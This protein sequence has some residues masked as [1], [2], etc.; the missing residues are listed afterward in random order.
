L[1]CLESKSAQS[2][3][4]NSLGI[5]YSELG[6]ETD[7][8]GVLR[9]ALH[10]DLQEKNWRGV[11][12]YLRNLRVTLINLSRR[13]E[14]VTTLSLARGL[15]EA[16]H[17]ED[18]V[19]MAINDQTIEAIQQGRF[20]DA[21]VLDA[22]FRKRPKPPP[23]LYTPGDGEFW[24]CLSRFYQGK[25]TDEEWQEGYDLTVRHRNVRM[26]YVFLALRAEWDL[27][28]NRNQRALEAIDQALQITKKLGTPT[29]VYHDLRAWALA[30]LG[31]T[32]DARTELEVGSQGLYA[33]ETYLALGEREQARKC[34]LNAYRW[35]WGEG[36][37][38][39]HW[40]YLERSRALLKQLGEPEPKLPPFDPSKVQPIPYEKEIRAA[41]ERLKAERAKKEE[42]QGS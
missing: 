33:A 8:L 16:A 30:K 15:V 34:A 20:V 25:L 37:P 42:K 2:Y 39:I 28:E 36:P 26:Q 40:Y 17:D 11:A 4:L 1:P 10:L 38:Y 7:A 31:R 24:H 21:E 9:K 19:S 29:P 14:G 27:S 35:A 13:S 41:I 12:T 3:I 6:C 22:E 23:A 18:G 32:A 5:A